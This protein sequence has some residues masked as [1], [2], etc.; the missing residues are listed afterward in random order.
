MK[1][2]PTH[3]NLVPIAQPATDR[4]ELARQFHAEVVRLGSALDEYPSLPAGQ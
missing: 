3:P 4:K 1:A 2:Y